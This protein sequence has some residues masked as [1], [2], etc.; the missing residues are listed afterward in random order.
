[1]SI[2]IIKRAEFT[3]N[4][5]FVGGQVNPEVAVLENGKVVIG[6]TA[7]QSAVEDGGDGLGI[8]A[9]ARIFN[10]N[11]T[12]A[13]SEFRVNVGI[14]E[15]QRITDILALSDGTFLVS[16]YTTDSLVDG[17]STASLVRHFHQN[18]T[19]LSGEVLVNADTGTGGQASARMTEIEQGKVLFAWSD[20]ETDGDSGGVR[21]GVFDV[22]THTMGNLRTINTNTTGTQ[23]SPALATNKDGLVLVAWDDYAD[24]TDTSGSSVKARIFNSEFNQV[25]AEFLVNSGNTTSDQKSSS[26]AALKN[27]NFVVTYTDTFSGVDGNGSAIVF[28]IYDPAGNQV[29]GLTIA[30]SEIDDDQEFG[31]VVALGD[32]RFVISWTTKDQSQDGDSY[33]IKARIFNADGSAYGGEFLVNS[34]A[35]GQ[36]SR[37]D[38]HT[39]DDGLLAFVWEAIDDIHDGSNAAI[40]SR[41]I[42]VGSVREG[43]NGSDSLRGNN[44]RD[45]FVGYGGN[46]V[47]KGFGGKDV[48]FGGGGNDTL[49]LGAGNDR[50]VGGGGRDKLYLGKGKDVATG[51]G[52]KDVF[53]FKKR[54]GKDKITDFQNGKD[55]LRG[56]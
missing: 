5:F 40:K 7:F 4:H 11:G 20:G 6:W 38:L 10:A 28:K 54:D 25:V 52:G 48:G 53:I 8:S 46:D 21:G 43:G 3:A 18:G 51:G 13:V 32:G 34:I 29:Q 37:V 39:M 50:G 14:D 33:A 12:E 1:M 24:T 16:F 26:V 23:G 2:N 31:Q 17:N 9:K 19:P 47:F 49:I 36:Q 30:N 45:E 42:D 27:G 15:D 55:K 22:A 44:G 41:I 35:D 56:R